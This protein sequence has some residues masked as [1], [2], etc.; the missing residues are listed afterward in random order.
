[1]AQASDVDAPPRIPWSTEP[2]PEI[3][4]FAKVLV[5]DVR[6]IAMRSCDT[7][8]QPHA[9]SPVATRWRETGVQAEAV[10]V[11]IPDVVDDALFT[12][13]DAI[14]HGVLR[15]KFISS[16]GQEVDLTEEGLGELAGWYVGPE[17]WLE[18]FAEERFVD[19]LAD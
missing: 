18:M 17:G 15:L 7:Q 13:L 4:E 6:D 2:N 5:R 19:D 14:D 16:N 8:L 3:E 10:R 12:L 1:M 11:L 9:G